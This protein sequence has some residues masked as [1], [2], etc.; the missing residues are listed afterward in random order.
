LTPFSFIVHCATG[1]SPT[2]KGVTIRGEIRIYPE[3]LTIMGRGD[4]RTTKG[5]TFKGSYG[6][7]RPHHKRVSVKAKKAA[8]KK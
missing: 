4:K 5:K 3:E 7:T 6:I 2:P 1:L 8:A